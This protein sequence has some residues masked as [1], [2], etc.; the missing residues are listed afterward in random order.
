[1]MLYI[2]MFVIII[3]TLYSARIILKTLG[4][5]DFGL[6]NIV[7]GIVLMLSF[8]NSSMSLSVNR[9]LAFELG[10]KNYVKLKAVV[11][12][13]VN[14]HILLAVFVII[15]GESVGLWFVNCKLNIPIDRMDAANWVYQFSILA[16]VISI[17]RVP[18]NACIIAHEDMSAF[19]YISI[20]EA[21]LKLVV[22]YLLVVIQ[23]DKLKIYAVLIFLVSLIISII[24]YIFS[25]KKYEECTYHFIRDAALFKSIINYAGLSTFGN[26]AT[27]FVSQG[28]N[29]LLNIF[30]GPITNAATGISLQV[31]NAVSSFITNIYTAINPQIVKSYANNDREYMLKIVY[32]STKL[33]FFLLFMISLPLILETKTVLNLWLYKAPLDS[34]LF[35][36]LIL[37]NS[38]V[39]YLCTPSIIALQAT[40]KI[41]AVH[42]ITGS[43]NLLN[44][45]FSYICLNTGCFSYVVFSIQIFVSAMMSTSVLFIQKKQLNIGLIEYSN[46]ILIPIVK[47]VVVSSIIPI[48]F[49]FSY[50]S[51]IMRLFFT[52]II[53]IISISTSVYYLGL[54]KHFRIELKNIILMKINHK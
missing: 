3:I 2:R 20:I 15:I 26:M 16:F 32:N 24:Y 23:F 29:I 43:I 28:Q 40:G 25:K 10:S 50:E 17:I 54:D 5:E 49:C 1:M 8:L 9:F 14:V 35:C 6:Y 31:N 42:L 37:I 19:A 38:L 33:T 48:Y 18:Y 22:V 21:V 34:V 11:S 12:T 13:S 46:K 52:V 4:I 41:A 36:K 30:F 47:V 51:G 27:V 44:L 53:S 39:F 45:L 7:G